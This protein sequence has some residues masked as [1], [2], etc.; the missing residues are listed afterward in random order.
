MGGIDRMIQ[1]NAATVEESAA[2]SRNL[3]GQ[4]ANLAAVVARF[5]GQ[6][7]STSYTAAYAAPVP[8]RTKRKASVPR[9]AAAQAPIAAP[10]KSPAP[11][12]RTFAAT[13]PLPALGSLA[14]DMSGNN[15]LEF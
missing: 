1:Q 6:G 12:P 10:A 15:W 3:S 9:R 8:A 14:V 4:A 2:A 5:R 7:M 11:A 13:A